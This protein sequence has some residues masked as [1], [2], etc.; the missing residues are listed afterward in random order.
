MKPVKVESTTENDNS[1][2]RTKTAEDSSDEERNMATIH[3]TDV[4]DWKC[5]DCGYV[6]KDSDTVCDTCETSKPIRPSHEIYTNYSEKRPSTS[7]SD[8]RSSSPASREDSPSPT[9]F[10]QQN[11]SRERSL[12]KTDES[13]YE[14]SSTHSSVL[15]R[16]HQRSLQS[17]S[18]DDNEGPSSIDVTKCSQ[19]S[20][21]KY[22]ING[23][24]GVASFTIIHSPLRDQ[25]PQND[26]Y[27][28]EY[29]NSASNASSTIHKSSYQDKQGESSSSSSL[30]RSSKSE[31][32][33]VAYIPDLPINIDKPQILENMIREALESRY[34]QTVLNV[35]CYTELGIG[36]IYLS[37]DNDKHH[38][39][40]NIKKIL[41]EPTNNIT[42][43]VVD[44]LELISYIVI[45]NKNPNDLPTIDNICQ[46]WVQ[47][48]KTRSPPK[49]EQLSNQFQNIFRIVTHSLDELINAM[50]VKDLVINNQIASVYFRA[51]CC[52]L[53]DLPR[54]CN[55]DRLKQAI[56]EQITDR[57]TSRELMHIQYN[58]N[59]ANAVILTSGRARIWMSHNSIEIDGRT[60][61]KKDQLACRLIIQNVP[62]AISTALIQNHR[63]FANSVIKILPSNDH[64]I[65]EL[66]NRNIYE[67]C[68]DLGALRI[69]DHVLRIEAYTISSNPEDSDINAENWY[70]TEMCDYKS[71]IMPFMSD[72]HHRIFRYKWNPQA[73]LDQFRRWTSKNRHSN[74]KNQVEHEKVCNHKRHLLRMTVM[75]NTMG[76]IKKGYY[77]IDE[78]EIKLKPD[79]LKTIVYNHKSKLQHGKT[80]LSSQALQCPYPHT[81]VEVINEDCLIVYKK[82]VSQ[83]CRPVI[84][85]MA[86][87]TTPGGGY[88]RGDGAQEETL[89][90]RSNYFQSLDRELDDGK[91]SARFYCNSNGELEALNARDSLYPM[92]NYGAIYTSGMTVFRQPEEIGYPFMDIPMYDVCGIAMAAYRDPK[93]DKNLLTSK[94]SIGTRKKIENIFAIAYQHKHDCL[95]LSALGCG[96]FR[97]PPKH[98][99]TIFKSVIDQYAGFFKSVYFAIIDDH[100][101]GQ[102]FNPNGN[103]E[104]FRTV[105]KDYSAVPRKH[106][107]VDMMIGPWKILKQIN[108]TEVKLSDIK[109]CHLKPCRDGGKCNHL[110]NEQH[111]QEY[112]HPP[113]CPNTDNKTSCKEKHDDQHILWF[114]HRLQCSYGSECTLVDNDVTHM[115]EFEHPEFC[116]DGGNCE[117]LDYE[118]LKSYRHLPLCR[119]RRQCVEYNRRPNDHCM[120]FRHCIPM[121]RF[122]KFCTRFHD[123]KH[124]QEET[125]PFRSPPCPF[126]PFHC[127]AYNTL[128]RTNSIK[129]LPIDIQNHCLKYS[130]V[131]RYGRQCHE[132]SDV[133]LNNTIHVARHMCPYDSKCTKKHNEDHLN[134]FSHSDIPDIRRLCLYQNY[135]CRDKRKSEHILQ[136]RHNGNYD[137]SGVINYF[138]QNRMIDFVSNQ[139]HMLKAIQD[140][141]IH[142]KQTLSIPKEIQKFIKGLQPVH[143]CSKIIFESILVHGHVM[144]CEHME[145]L[146]KPRFAAQAAQEHKHVRAILD[147]YKLPKIE[148]HVRV[149]I[150]ELISQKYSTKY[151]SNSAFVIDSSSSMTSPTPNDFDE[152]ICKEERF[153]KSM[154]KAEE[155]DRIRKRAID[156][157]EAS[158]NLQ[159]DPTGIKYAPDK[160]LGTNKHIFSILGAHFGHYYGDIFLVF[161][162]EVMLHP[163]ANFSPQA[164]TTFNSGRT[165]SCRPWV[166]DPGSDEAK[167]KCFHQSKLHCSIPG[168]EYVAAAELI[169]MTGLHKKTMDIN[170]KDIL[171]RWKKVDSHQVFE[172]HLPQL[173]P[174]DYIDAV[175]IPKNLFNSLTSAAQESAKK[176]FGHSLHLT[177]LEVNLGLNG[178]V[179]V[180]LLDKSRSKYQ[181]Y[182]IDKLIEKIEHPTHFYGTVITLAPSK[183]SDHILVPITINKAYDQ[184]RHTH[185]GNTSSDD[186]YIYWKAMYGDMM[187]TLSNEPINPDKIEPNIRYLVCYVAERPSTTTTNYNESYSYINASDPY[188]HEIIMANGRCSSSSRTF[189]RGCN[190]EGFLTYCLKIE[191]KTGQVTLSHAGS[192]G[193]YCYETITCNFPKTTLDLNKLIYI[194]VSA[195]SQ[196]VPIQNLIISFE[197]IPDLHPSFDKNFK[198]GNDVVS[199]DKKPHRRDRSPSPKSEQPSREKSSSLY[200]KAEHVIR[201]VFGYGGNDKKLEPCSHSINCLLQESPKHM[202][203]FSHPCPYSELCTKKDKEPYL[204]HEPHRVEQCS[205]KNTCQKLNDPIHRAKYQHN[206]YPDFLIPCRHERKCQD[207]TFHHRIKYSHGEN[208]DIKKYAKDVIPDK[209]SPKSTLPYQAAASSDVK[210]DKQQTSCRYGSDCRDK[211]DSQ[212]C[213]KYSHPYSSS[214]ARDLCT[215]CRYGRDCRDKN[216]PQH[217]SKYSHPHNDRSKSSNISSDDQIPCRY[218][219]DC[220]DKGDPRHYSKYSHDHG[221]RP[222]SSLNHN[223]IPCRYG[224]DC[225]DKHDSRHCSKYSHANK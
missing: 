164:A 89:F 61:M 150:Q 70:E 87:A 127:Q 139:E 62:K 72:P 134:S 79:R 100:N 13:E 63:I 173:I 200:Q 59:G 128:S 132:T 168:Y 176:T 140:Y 216:D 177:D 146:K 212:H 219:C 96:A 33:I 41:I 76:V 221:S 207:T 186:T 19:S 187:I 101:T 147:R 121:C 10:R 208:V 122:G 35:K 170:I 99:A 16:K 1:K 68:I 94:Y 92:D 51:D 98:I 123:D 141:A 172:A 155:I 144:S 220:R 7:L 105:F 213:S 4:Q 153:L 77:R 49:C 160:V 21:S 38:L 201:N 204:T 14:K 64:V 11:S 211:T 20:K 8:S 166:K 109:I 133:H 138:G 97:N 44:E 52:F 46:R 34:K 178:D 148:D 30:L 108:D 130:H 190:I 196:K 195:G 84:L 43:S 26:G 88:R 111:C 32:P 202:K 71:D 56:S 223:Q 165:F 9:S 179:N 12:T 157:A 107:L 73:F 158:W 110:K 131:C 102:D 60:I 199:R 69:G 80:I 203:E 3:S 136:Y 215:P 185:K 36:I 27:K 50:S 205:S 151:G 66:S 116:R 25:S 175:Y 180:Q 143:R 17:C 39:I 156:I 167:I 86:N 184:Y 75:L 119:H 103:Y 90:R 106:R 58:E 6:N 113:L 209:S 126:T 78:K 45:D 152:T 37:N 188:R 162:N 142:L 182:V 191:K 118:H 225:R 214:G 197:Q 189:Y 55:L 22:L 54:T 67:T 159:G 31:H 117:N 124:L 169:A 24:L 194:H 74:D 161:K 120:K 217:C 218:G 112:S 198:P 193:I 145:H 206:G 95:V 42:V 222:S 224:R 135:E 174:L 2:P 65:L 149:Y 129:T 125:H 15:S 85:N 93:V 23:Y 83:G 29:N 53:E 91:P 137:S 48:Y 183:F 114:K 154:L 5:R 81:S 82:L 28:S 18:L 171:N 115:N 210:T 57:Y 163:D 104:P 181:N 192:N 47:L 40:K